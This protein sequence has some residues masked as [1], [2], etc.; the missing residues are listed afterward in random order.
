MSTLLNALSEL[1]RSVDELESSESRMK[2]S[3][4]RAIQSAGQQD[5]FAGGA[6]AAN[7]NPA[8]DPAVL[9]QKL[10]VAIER[11]EEVLREG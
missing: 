3:I 10:D 9:A 1:E 4:A 5:L 8:P 6:G 7:G 11:V 2:D